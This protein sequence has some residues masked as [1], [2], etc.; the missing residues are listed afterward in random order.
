VKS[1]KTT[2][3]K[4]DQFLKLHKE[5]KEIKEIMELTGCSYFQVYNVIRGRVATVPPAKQEGDDEPTELPVNLEEF[6]DTESFIEYQI[7]LLMNQISSKKLNLSARASALRQLVLIQSDFKKIKLENMIKRPNGVL[8]VNIMR[9]LNPDLTDDQ[10]LKII[11]EE[12][13]KLKKI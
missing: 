7:T 10:I 2:K 3:H 11:A 6:Q 8:I 4:R 5:G 12:T 9:R 13:E 1:L